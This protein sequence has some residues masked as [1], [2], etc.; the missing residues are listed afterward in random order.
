MGKNTRRALLGFAIGA[1]TA[2][3]SFYQTK[4]AQEAEALRE[5]RL[6]AIRAEER[7]QDQQFQR[8][9]T[10]TALAAQS[11]RDDKIAQQQAE[12]DAAQAEQ[13]KKRDIMLGEQRQREISSMAANQPAPNT[14]YVEGTDA[15]GV[16]FAMTREEFSRLPPDQRAGMSFRG[17][18]QSAPAPAA[19]A[20]APAPAPAGGGNEYVPDYVFIDGKLVPNPAKK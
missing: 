10:Q 20:D 14:G 2:A 6:A 11:A 8:E 12:R 9:Q 3:Q 5:Q 13:T 19:A 17:Q 15:K 16:P 7:G 1:G 4:A 18:Y